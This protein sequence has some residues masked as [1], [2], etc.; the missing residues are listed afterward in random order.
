[1]ALIRKIFLSVISN[2]SGQ[3]EGK[4]QENVFIGNCLLLQLCNYSMNMTK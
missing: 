3:K 2:S 4:K 1:M